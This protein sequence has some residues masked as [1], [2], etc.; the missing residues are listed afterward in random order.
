MD[1]AN[2][3]PSLGWA[4][5][6]RRSLAQRANADVCLALALLHHLAIGRNVPLGHLSAYLAELA[7][8]LVVE[9]VPKEDA[10]VQRLLASRRDVF[11]DYSLDGFR[12]AF[13]RDWVIEEEA[14]IEG[15]VRVLFRLRRRAPSDEAAVN[16]GSATGR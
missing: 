4:H 13:A 6:E 15:T 2:P 8:R 3:S 11:P 12:D 1:L 9:F 14:P 10:M 16:G 5:R 7:P